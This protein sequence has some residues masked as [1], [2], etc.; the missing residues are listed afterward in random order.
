MRSAGNPP[1]PLP[2]GATASNRELL[3]S[4][5]AF[6]QG[7]QPRNRSPVPLRTCRRALE[8]GNPEPPVAEDRQ[9]GLDSLDARI[10]FP[11]L[12][13][14]FLEYFFGAGAV[15]VHYQF[16]KCTNLGVGVLQGGRLTHP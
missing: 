8:V 9:M 10:Q 13:G 15:F 14:N 16:P 7:A 1:T 11:Q 4:A 6:D 12:R 5:Q 3:R 2:G